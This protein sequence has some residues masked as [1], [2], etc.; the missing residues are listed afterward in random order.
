MSWN[1]K[2]VQDLST[3]LDSN[4]KLCQL[5]AHPNFIQQLQTN[6]NKLSKYISNSPALV[7]EL[8][9][10]LTVPPIDQ[11]SEG[12]KYKLPMLAI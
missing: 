11:D 4:P 1:N 10:Y 9:T 3:L 6:C 2:T 8:V 7:S 12:R 5:L